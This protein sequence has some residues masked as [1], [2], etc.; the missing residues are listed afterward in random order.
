MLTDQ[1]LRQVPQRYE[2]LGRLVHWVVELSKFDIQ[3]K[4]HSAIK[5]QT[6]ADFVIE[7]AISDE[8]TTKRQETTLKDEPTSYDR[9]WILYVDGSL[10]TLMSEAGIILITLDG[11]V[12]DYALWFTFLTSNNEMAHEALITSLKLTKELEVHRLKVFSDS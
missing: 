6:L 4:P 5:L 12:V 2:M 8:G 9:P 7:C 11:M 1:P 10:T 3:Y